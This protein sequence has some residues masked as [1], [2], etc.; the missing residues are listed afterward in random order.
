SFEVPLYMMASIDEDVDKSSLTDQDDVGSGFHLIVMFYNVYSQT[1]EER[2]ARY[3]S[4]SHSERVTPSRSST[5]G[6]HQCSRRDSPEYDRRDG[7]AISR[8]YID[9][10]DHQDRSEPPPRHGRYES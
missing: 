2:S 1:A 9:E 8:K 3:A 6:D 7:R 4:T 5:S 10:R